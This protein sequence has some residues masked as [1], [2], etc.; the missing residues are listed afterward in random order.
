[1]KLRHRILSIALLLLITLVP[2]SVAYAQTYAFQVPTQRVDVYWEP[3]GTLSVTY[4]ITF[5]NESYADPIDYVDVGLP[6]NSY[7]VSN[8]SASIDG[9]PISHIAYSPYIDSGVE[10][11]LGAYAIQPGQSGTVRMTATNVSNVLYE[12]NEDSSYASALFMPNYFDSDFVNGSSDI[13]VVFHLPP[14]VQPSEP[15]WHT[16]GHPG[17]PDTPV[18]GV[19]NTGRITYTWRNTNA[20]AGRDYLFG[21][22]FPARSVRE[23]SVTVPTF[24][25]RYGIDPDV[26][27]GL[28]VCLCFAGFFTFIVVIAVRAERSRKLKYLPPK[29]SVEGHGIKRGLTA[30][31]AAIL[32]EQPMDKILSMIMFS[33]VKKGAAEV[34]T[35]D[36]LDVARVTKQPTGLKEY[37]NDFLNAF[38]ESD[39][40]KRRRELQQMMVRMVRGVANKMRGFSKRETVEFYKK[41][42]ADAWAEVEAADTPKV[43]S[44]AFDEN[45]EWTMLD[46]NYDRRTRDVFSDGPVYLPRWYGGYNPAY[47]TAGKTSSAPSVGR[48]S[49]SP[50]RSTGSPSLPTLP[51]G[52]FAASVVG[53]VQSFA[54]S[55]VGNLSDFTG[56]VT[57]V[58]NPPPPPSTSS[59]GGGFSGGGS[60]CACACAGCACACAGGGR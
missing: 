54:S 39:K 2:L 5:R 14:G 31:E 8:V 33:V 28:M 22:S 27:I 43:K 1:M 35:R 3:N 42:T 7:S 24:W 19:D 11:G 56:G 17:F 16:A 46:P 38:A 29:I 15:R 30:P 20:S 58:T 47:N 6:N 10:L 26:V 34:V 13:T 60:S 4:E 32:L 50:T 12:D 57:K 51:G 9:R 36:P 59:G 23:G 37:E 45:L 44:E 41:I 55:V 52:D 40:A 21:A 25:Q 18:T 53:G 48:S 49:G